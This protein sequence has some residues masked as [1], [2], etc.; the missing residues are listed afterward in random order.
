MNRV[1]SAINNQKENIRNRIESGLTTQE[2]VNALHENLNME[3]SEFCR[4]QELKSLA[5]LNQKLSLDE[6][7][8]IYRHLGATPEHFNSQPI[9][10]KAVLTQIF[11]E[12]LKAA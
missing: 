5:V 2:K 1:T 12:L 7:N 6:G 10:V 9:E 3:F 8:T 11:S 4:F